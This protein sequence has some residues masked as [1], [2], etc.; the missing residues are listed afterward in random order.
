MGVVHGFQGR[1]LAAEGVV[2]R[3][4]DVLACPQK[5]HRTLSCH[6]CSLLRPTSSKRLPVRLRHLRRQK[7]RDS[8][9]RVT[10]N[11]ERGWPR[12]CRIHTSLVQR[13]GSSRFVIALSSS[14]IDGSSRRKN[15]CHATYSLSSFLTPHSGLCP[16]E[17]LAPG[18]GRGFNFFLV[19][20][21]ASSYGPYHSWNPHRA[22]IK[23]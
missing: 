7:E 9:G 12:F 6:V 18:G 15:C 14:A 5:A 17:L 3:K 4:I 1:S 19:P 11:C 20:W 13:D 2:E 16:S 21:M 22:P 23:N 8:A 10:R